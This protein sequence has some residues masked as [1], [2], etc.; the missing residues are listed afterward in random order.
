ML[1]LD[2]SND[3]PS[4]SQRLCPSVKPHHEKHTSLLFP[5][6]EFQPGF[7]STR[8]YVSRRKTVFASLV[9]SIDAARC[10]DHLL[11]LA[12]SRALNGHHN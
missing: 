2:N 12:R 5:V 1:G 3:F 8:T 11:K 10:I 4:V 6:Q 9:A 7:F